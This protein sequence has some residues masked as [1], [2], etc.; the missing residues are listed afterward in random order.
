MKK[1][2]ALLG[3][4]IV[5]GGAG[6]A[7][8]PVGYGGAS[9]SVYGEYPNTYQGHGYS[10]YPYQY[11]HSGYYYKGHY[12]WHRP[13]DRDHYFDRYHRYPYYYR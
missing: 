3:L 4:A 1:L 9:V 6:C 5:V 7:V 12:P 13:Y 8:E 10:H 11:G 2:I